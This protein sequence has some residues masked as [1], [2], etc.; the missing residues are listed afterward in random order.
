MARARKV[1]E[2]TTKHLS[3][4]EREKRKYAEKQISADKSD[5]MKVPNKELRDAVA[6]KEYKRVLPELLKTDVIGNLD[7]A[8]MIAY[9]NAYSRYIEATE[10][11]KDPNEH[12]VVEQGNGGTKPNPLIVISENAYKEMK[13]AGECLGM[14]VNARLSAANLKVKKEEEGLLEAFG[15]I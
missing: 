2:M 4:A 6:K 9:A 8:Q 10:K 15:D 7:R 14:T 11:L 1:V 12:L 5:I 3:R 13:A